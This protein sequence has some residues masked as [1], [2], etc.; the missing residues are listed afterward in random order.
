VSLSRTVFDSEFQMAG[1]VLRN[2]LTLHRFCCTN[3][4]QVS[5]GTRRSGVSTPTASELGE[6]RSKPDVGAARVVPWRRVDRQR[7]AN[8]I[9]HFCC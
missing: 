4:M 1:A 2:E 9:W 3:A 5:T 8:V 7:H 6:R